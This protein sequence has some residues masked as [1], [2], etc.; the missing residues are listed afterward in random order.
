MLSVSHLSFSYQK[1]IIFSD[2]SF[3]LE[4]G[5]CTVVVGPNGSGKSTLLSLLSGVLRPRQGSICA[6]GNI[7]LVPQGNGIFEDMTVAENLRFFCN[8]AHCPVPSPL[9]F[10]LDPYAGTRASRLSGG[11]QKR[12]GIACTYVAAPDYWLFDEPCA[13]LD[14]LWRQELSQ[15]IVNLKSQGHG[16]LYVGHDPGEFV[17]FYDHLLILNHSHSMLI[18]RKDIPAGTEASLIRQLLLSGRNEFEKEQ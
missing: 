2:L 18:A 15:L 10:G 8:L 5:T 4:P 9:P 1:K 16:I 3:Q 6:D 11:Y 7:G 17:A 12:L 13:G 14:I